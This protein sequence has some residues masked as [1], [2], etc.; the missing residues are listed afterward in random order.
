VVAGRETTE[1]RLRGSRAGEGGTG[2]WS[3]VAMEREPMDGLVWRVRESRFTFLTDRGLVGE[4]SDTDS[5]SEGGPDGNG[6]S[7][8]A[9]TVGRLAGGGAI[10]I[11]R[12]AGVFLLRERVVDC[13]MSS[14][15]QKEDDDLRAFEREEEERGYKTKGARRP[16]SSRSSRQTRACLGQLRRGE[17]MGGRDAYLSNTPPHVHSRPPGSQHRSIVG[18]AHSSP[19]IGPRTSSDSVLL[20]MS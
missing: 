9:T 16:T 18:R 7:P 3:W 6:V 17:W 12:L 2:G 8:S 10:L 11:P 15:G 13:M 14:W 5:G 20:P 19:R 1:G 4:G